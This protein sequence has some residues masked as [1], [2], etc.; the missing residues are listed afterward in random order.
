[1]DKNYSLKHP[2]EDTNYAYHI[3]TPSG[4][5]LVS[6]DTYSKALDLL[7]ELNNLLLYKRNYER[8]MDTINDMAKNK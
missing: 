5:F 4:E 3:Y 8:L 1:M 2:S 6:I 7:Y